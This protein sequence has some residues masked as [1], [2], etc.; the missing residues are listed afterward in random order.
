M[1][2]S[3]SLLRVYRQTP[4]RIANPIR[5]SR[6]VLSLQCFQRPVRIRDHVNTALRRTHQD[7]IIRWHISRRRACLRSVENLPRVFQELAHT[8]S[9][10][11]P[12][13]NSSNL[14]IPRIFSVSVGKSSCISASSCLYLNHLFYS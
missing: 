4:A 2:A 10:A 14:Q 12:T 3:L 11:L 9:I 6:T 7:R 5:R 8:A 13:A 1:A